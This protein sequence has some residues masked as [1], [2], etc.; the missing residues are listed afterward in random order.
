MSYHGSRQMSA[1]RSDVGGVVRLASLWGVLG[2]HAVVGAVC[3]VRGRPGFEALAPEPVRWALAI[4]LVASVIVMT[5]VVFR[6][7]PATAAERVAAHVALVFVAVATGGWFWVFWATRGTAYDQLAAAF[8][9]GLGASFDPDTGSGFAGVPWLAVA[10]SAGLFAWAWVTV[11]YAQK[12][13][14]ARSLAARSAL[15]RHSAAIVGSLLTALALGG[16]LHLANG[17]V[18]NL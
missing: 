7:P 2:W 5:E 10:A 13:F 8:S 12:Y 1:I 4:M 16:V 18:L 14:T 11:H 17:F 15:P 9:R 3:L 6:S